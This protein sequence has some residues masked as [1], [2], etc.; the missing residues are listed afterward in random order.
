MYHVFTSGFYVSYY[1]ISS[2]K[3]KKHC[4]VHFIIN[5]IFIENECKTPYECIAFIFY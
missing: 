5:L 1:H 3:N 4:K 2:H